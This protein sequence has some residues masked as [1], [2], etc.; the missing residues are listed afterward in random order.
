MLLI[1]SAMMQSF[2]ATPPTSTGIAS[3]GSIAQNS[4]TARNGMHEC[5]A[6]NDPDR[7]EICEEQQAERAFASFARN[8]IGREQR[9]EEGIAEENCGVELTEQYGA[10]STK[11]IAATHSRPKRQ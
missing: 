3:T 9:R 5:L 8:A 7:T 2:A 4:I 11:G 10:K 1:S 6:R